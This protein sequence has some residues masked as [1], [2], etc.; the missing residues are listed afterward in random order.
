MLNVVKIHFH[1]TVFYNVLLRVNYASQ[2]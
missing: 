1:Y 2:E